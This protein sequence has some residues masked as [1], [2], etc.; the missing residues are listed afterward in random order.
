MIESGRYD[1]KL[2]FTKIETALYSYGKSKKKI[3][4]RSVVAYRLKNSHIVDPKNVAEVSRRKL[5]MNI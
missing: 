4:G 3:E 2:K 5:F 1:P